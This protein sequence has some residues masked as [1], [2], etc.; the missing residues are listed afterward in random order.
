MYHIHAAMHVCIYSDI[1]V[2]HTPGGTHSH[3]HINMH[4][5]SLIHKLRLRPSGKQ[6][7][8]LKASFISGKETISE[9]GSCPTLEPLGKA[10]IEC[11]RKLG[12]GTWVARWRPVNSDPTLQVTALRVIILI[13]VKCKLSRNFSRSNN[14]SLFFLN[15][16][17]NYYYF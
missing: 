2:T 16:A 12:V 6:P 17:I 10:S 1:L 11:Y 9:G 14:T 15:P 5:H 7:V 8:L 3:I 13:S 4:T